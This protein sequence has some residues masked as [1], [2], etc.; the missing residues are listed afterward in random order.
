[1]RFNH[2]LKSAVN[3]LQEY[4]GNVPLAVFLKNYFRCYKQMGARDRKQVAGLVYNYF[5]L[6]RA[7][8]SMMVDEKILLGCFLC[9]EASALFAYFK[10][11]WQDQLKRPLAE[12]LDF[13]RHELP[14]FRVT[15]IFPWTY[16][17]SEGIDREAFCLSF[18]QQ[19]RL[20]IRVRGQ[21]QA[22][23]QQALEKAAVKFEWLN[24]TC[25]GL[26]NGTRLGSLLQDSWYEVQ[27]Y[28]SQLT[29]DFFYPPQGEKSERL[30]L[31][32]WDSCA[33]SGG[34]SILLYD[35]YPQVHLLVSD[36]RPSIL[37]NLQARFQT[38]GI[39]QYHSVLLDLTSDPLPVI[40][41]RQFDMI[42]LDVPCS[43]SGTWARTPEQL[44]FFKK[45]E[46]LVS[47]QRLQQRIS[48]NVIPF[49]KKGSPIIYITCSVFRQEN[50]A[51]SAYI[52]EAHGIQLEQQRVLTGFQHSADTMF[53]ARLVSS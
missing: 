17:L 35:R 22:L 24:E 41:R 43:G 12:K 32:V 4:E 27:D 49:L 3:I 1:M 2:Y 8:P 18:L 50:E 46:Q 26:P 28:S 19:P 45:D 30:P 38:A 7:L 13:L 29:A 9:E 48:S 25:I 5:R 10:P 51:I 34:K 14:D 40:G 53:V 15:D 16:E 36:V 6:G 11:A 42:L 47:F 39:H 23:I 44:Y 31:E 52:Q 21:K 37:S 20:F 33:A